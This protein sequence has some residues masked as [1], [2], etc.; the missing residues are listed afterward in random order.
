MEE[1]FSLAEVVELWYGNSGW[2]DTPSPLLSGQADDV[3]PTLESFI[4]VEE[5]TEGRHLV[6]NPYFFMVDTAG[7]QLPYINEQD[8]LYVPDKEVRNLKITNGEVDYKVQAIF[9]DDFPSFL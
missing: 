9:I 6:A 8:E 1:G 5:T 3:L 2:A 7:Q 4:L